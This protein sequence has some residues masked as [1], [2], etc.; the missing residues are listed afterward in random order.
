MAISL[1]HTFG[2]VIGNVLE[3]AIE[4]MLQ[5]FADERGLYLDKKGPRKARA[6]RK[7]TW[8]D[9]HGNTHDLDFVLERGGTDEVIGTPVAFI[10][11]AWRRYTKHSRNK[12][13]EIQGAIQAL[14]STYK[15]CCPFTGA[16]LAGVFTE[17]AINQLKSLGFHIL[18]F[19]YASILDAFQTAGIEASFDE[20]TPEKEFRRKLGRWK[21]T[22][23]KARRNV[24]IQLVKGH[25]QE[26]DKFL[27]A[28]DDVVKRRIERI[29]V[30]PLHGR[31]TE[32]FSVGEAIAFLSSYK[33]S[34]VPEA[35]YR[36]EIHIRY[37]SGD[38][39]TAEFTERT[40][41]V[42]FLKRYE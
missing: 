27:S 38:R 40:A 1:A 8:A 13:Q 6:G 41:A 9:F 42:E 4:P 24:A 19:S 17:G 14:V 37:S 22:S 20:H 26:V 30:I 2:Q 16:I 15:H 12:A 10:E 7:V 25:Q 34:R 3:D 31:E 11:T 21:A 39:I 36:Y 35:V 18:F 29:I 33:S 28:L 32:C 5:R 23:K